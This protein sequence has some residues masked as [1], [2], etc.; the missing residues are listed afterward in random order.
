MAEETPKTTQPIPEASKEEK[1]A[2]EKPAAEPKKAEAPSG[3][4]ADLVKQIEELP[5]KDLAE[6][7]KTL[8]ERFG[9]SAL[10]VAP[11]AT[12]TAAPEE[13][14]EKSE[15]TIYLTDAG[16]QKIAVIKAVRE[17]RSDLGLKEAKDLVDAAPKNVAV[18]LPKEE[19]EAAKKKLEDAGG[20]V[21]LK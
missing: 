16:T 18:K 3:K 13:A 4:F 21:E 11:A 10:A 5:V 6:L 7:V 12:G 19:A 14:E 1:P 20:K 2:E 9:V 8:E 17:I 15:Y